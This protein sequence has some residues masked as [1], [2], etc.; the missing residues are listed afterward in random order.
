MRIP[1]RGE[2]RKAA[3]C[4]GDDRPA[5]MGP[6]PMTLLIDRA[7]PR[8]DVFPTGPPLWLPNGVSPSGGPMAALSTASAV[9]LPHGASLGEEG[10]RG[11]GRDGGSLDR[12]LRSIRKTGLSS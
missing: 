9:L 12:T 7:A 2:R 3:M 5:Q 8:V 4:K 1:R 6:A 10:S 11:I